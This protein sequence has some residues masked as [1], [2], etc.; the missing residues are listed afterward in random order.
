MSIVFTFCMLINIALVACFDLMQT[1]EKTTRCFYSSAK[2][3]TLIPQKRT[4]TT[5]C[6]STISR[7]AIHAVAIIYFDCDLLGSSILVSSF[8]YGGYLKTARI[9]FL[10]WY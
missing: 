8:V 9:T 4:R 10:G 5:P 3:Q 7:T 1:R 6:T 2:Y